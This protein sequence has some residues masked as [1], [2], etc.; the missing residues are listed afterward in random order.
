MAAIE[1]EDLRYFLHLA[2]EKSLS[3]AARKLGTTQP[4]MSRRLELFES[5]L[6]AILFDRFPSGLRLSDTGRQILDYA[7]RMEDAALAAQRIAVGSSA[8]LTGTVRV[9]SP[10]WLGARILSPLLAKFCAAHPTVTVELV[11]DAEALSLTRREIDVALRFGRFQQDGLMQRKI[12]SIPFELYAAAAYLK[13]KGP[14]DFFGRWRRRC[15]HYDERGARRK[16]CGDE[17]A[18]SLFAAG[19]C[20][21]LQQ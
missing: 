16:C 18:A 21:I 6:G 5:K 11:T 3:G 20:W 17:V 13:A 2:R 8:G 15:A 19:T 14:P 12:A 9:T 1:W 10:E 4:T 7:E